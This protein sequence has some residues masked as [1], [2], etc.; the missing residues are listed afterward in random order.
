MK[1]EYKITKELI[2]LWAKEYHLRGARNKISFAIWFLLGLFCVAAWIIAIAVQLTWAIIVLAL[3]IALIVY[4]LAFSRFVVWNRRYKV[5]ARS[6][7]VSEWMRSHEFNDEGITITDHTS[8]AV[9]KYENINDFTEK[10]NVV[11]IYLN[12][13]YAIRLYK[14]AFV[15]G[16]WEA[17]KALLT[18][19]CNLKKSNNAGEPPTLG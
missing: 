6:Y 2:Q 14:D 12:D 11:M 4:K 18:E 5:L 13:N 3:Y 1:N 7:G 17:C 10:G 19:K 15:E 16:S 9:W 8:V